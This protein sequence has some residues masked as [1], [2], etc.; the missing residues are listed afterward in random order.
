MVE[1]PCEISYTFHLGGGRRERITLKFDP[2]TFSLLSE[3]PT[4]AEAW[5]ALEVNKCPHCPLTVET[6][7]ECPFATALSSFIHG[8]DEFYSY[9][10]AVVEVAT[11]QRTT[12]SNHPLQD[13]MASII[14]L[15]G[16]TS[17]C[18]HL[19]F[20]RPMARFHLPFAS[21]EET[22]FRT[23]SIF[24][25]GEY[26]QAG[27]RGDAMIG[28]AG[29]QARY[30]AVALVNRSMAE[31]IRTAFSKDAVVNAIIILDTFAQAAPYL[32]KDKLEELRYVFSAKPG[33]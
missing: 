27:G 16:A 17:G 28:V 20:F 22:L 10:K 8:F 24:L 33:P 32:I 12:I 2:A 11:G 3:R 13:G 23:F 21:E 1:A 31:R 7:P 26:L 15:I 14:G 6:H 18:P 9:D 25:L 30:E 29:L 19:A 4:S 5:V